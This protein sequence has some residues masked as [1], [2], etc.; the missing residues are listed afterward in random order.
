MTTTSRATSTTAAQG[1]ERSARRDLA[2]LVILVV[3]WAF[4]GWL[5]WQ[6]ALSTTAQQLLTAV[7]LVLLAA[8]FCLAL[9]LLWIAHNVRIFRRKGQRT[10][11]PAVPIDYGTDWTRR[12]VVA[13]WAAVRAAR[14]VI[15]DPGPDRKS[16]VPGSQAVVAPAEER[17]EDRLVA[18][19]GR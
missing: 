18:R 10:G 6:V 7:A 1:P 13:D 16:F 14:I 11:R 12:P 4:F 9:T 8:A 15:V 17:P 3:P 5:W 2:H 19:T